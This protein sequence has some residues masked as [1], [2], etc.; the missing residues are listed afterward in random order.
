MAETA[1]HSK[2]HKLPA[3]TLIGVSVAILF[4]ALFALEISHG[5]FRENGKIA[6]SLFAFPPL[7]AVFWGMLARRRWALLVAR[8]LAFLGA[9]WFF[10]WTAIAIVVQYHDQYGPVWI[11]LTCVSLG[12]GGVL[13]AGFLGLGRSSTRRHYG[14]VCPQCE[15]SVKGLRSYF[16]RQVHCAKCGHS[17]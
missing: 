14:L 6:R 17:W 1:E 2:G 3:S 9:L 8:I 7:L 4:L 13:T 10:M 5:L 15:T 12:L 16:S 11:W